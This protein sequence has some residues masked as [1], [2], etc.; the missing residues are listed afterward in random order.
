[1]YGLK[2]SLRAWF[3]CFGKVVKSYGY[4]QSQVD[5]TMFYKHS[6]KG[7]ISIL[8]VYVDDIILTRDDIEELANLKRRMAQD[9]E[10]KDLGI[11]KC[12]LGMKFAR[13][14]ECIFV[15]QRK[16][17]LDLFK[18]TG[19]LGF[20]VAETPIEANLKLD[21]TKAENVIDRERFQKLV[22]KLIY[23]SHTHPDI[24]LL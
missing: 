21:T 1:M 17:I 8:I 9:F 3:E 18:E 23:L 6:E 14:K 12:F 2:Q 4:H 19:L 22:E 16:Y 5:H 11:L 10:M 24:A 20:K 13:S 7:K 15:N